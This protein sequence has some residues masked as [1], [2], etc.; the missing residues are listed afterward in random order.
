MAPSNLKKDI[1][2]R[3]EKDVLQIKHIQCNVSSKPKKLKVMN[4]Q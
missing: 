3:P 4:I 2:L 1:S